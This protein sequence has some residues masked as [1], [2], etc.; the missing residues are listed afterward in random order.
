[1]SSPLHN[2]SYAMLFV[3][4]GPLPVDVT[5]S[6][7]CWAAT[8]LSVG[9]QVQ[10]IIHSLHT[11]LTIHSLCRQ[12]RVRDLWLHRDIGNTTTWQPLAAPQLEPDGGVA[13]FRLE[14]VM[15]VGAR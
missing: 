15:P 7:D 11:V 12:V 10:Y 2:G 4:N 8:G 14:P 9:M 6:A 13:M 3:N 1:M 5:C